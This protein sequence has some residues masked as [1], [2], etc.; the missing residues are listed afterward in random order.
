MMFF[1]IAICDIRNGILSEWKKII[2]VFCLFAILTVLAF[3]DFTAASR[4]QPSPITF[5]VSIGDYFCYIFGGSSAQ[6]HVFQ[7]F[8]N[9]IIDGRIAFDFPS[10]WL[11]VFMFLLLFT[12]KYPYNDLMGFGKHLM[13]L[14]EKKHYWWLSK[15]LWCVV[16][17]I[18]YFVTAFCSIIIVALAFGAELS[19]KIST[20]FPYLRISDYDHILNPPWNILPVMLLLIP[21]GITLCLVQLLLSLLTSPLVSFSITSLFLVFGTF[22][23]SNFLFQNAAM[24]ARSYCFVDNGA[25]L[26]QTISVIIWICA[27]SVFAGYIYLRHID[28]INKDK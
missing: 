2:G 18:L 4:M 26:I 7:L 22:V 21:V 28:I 16:C 14:S 19:L 15:C 1:K 5:P 23:Q 6:T 8:N 3:L 11:T 17:T 10:I 13:I 24:A 25:T 20:Y 12:V 9:D 27:L